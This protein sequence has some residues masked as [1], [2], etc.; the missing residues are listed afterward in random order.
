MNNKWI[1]HSKTA[2]ERKYRMILFHHAGG[3]AASF[4]SWKNIVEKAELYPVQLPMRENRIQEPMPENV[5][6]IVT[7]FVKDSY[8]L[9]D[10][11]YILFGHSMG[12]MLAFETAKEIQRNGLRRPAAVFISSCNPP[13]VSEKNDFSDL[14]DEKLKSI[15]MEYGLMPEAILSEPNYL[16]YYLPIARA[17]FY[18]CANYNRECLND[19]KLDCPIVIMYGNKDA[20]LKYDELDKWKLYTKSVFSKYEFDGGHFYYFDNTEKVCNIID[21]VFSLFND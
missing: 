20:F 3:S 2:A 16:E 17:D 18:L 15:L 21:S 1:L 7:S 19:T 8:E 10:D 13:G 5:Y 6:D 14:S 11:A 9:F 12:G 4:I